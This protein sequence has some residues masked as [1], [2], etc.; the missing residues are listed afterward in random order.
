VREVRHPLRAREPA[1]VRDP[2][3]RRGRRRRVDR[4]DTIDAAVLVGP[5]ELVRLDLLAQVRRNQ[6]VMLDDAAVHVDDVERAIRTGPEVH[7]TEALVR[8]GNEI[9]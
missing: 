1:D 5:F 7:R 3:R 8:R 4:H 6:A 9:S 2:G